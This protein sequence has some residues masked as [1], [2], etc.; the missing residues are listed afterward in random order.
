MRPPTPC[1]CE[2]TGQCS[3]WDEGTL[4]LTIRSTH[5]PAGDL[6]FLLHKNPARTQ[7]FDLSFGRAHVFYP[8][9]SQHACTA[10][11]LLADQP[12][13]GPSRYYTVTVSG[14][15]RLSDLLTHLYV[16]VPVL[17]DSKH[18]WVGDEEVDKLLKHGAGWLERHPEREL[19]TRRYVR[20]QRSLVDF[21]LWR[22]PPHLPES[23]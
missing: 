2:C 11:L 5:K 16:L 7:S 8:E 20:H 3:G 17:D 19:I 21:R 12:D 18:Y 14:T 23:G 10:A 4:L 15:C 9:L 22:F 1:S 13:W 6:G